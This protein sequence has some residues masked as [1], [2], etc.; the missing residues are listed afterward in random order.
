[1]ATT[2]YY[3]SG[4]R[5]IGPISS[6]AL[7]YHAR[8][9]EI[10]PETEVRSSRS[11]KWIAA[12][13]V[14]GLFAPI[15]ATQVTSRIVQRSTPEQPKPVV[16]PLPVATSDT[17]QTADGPTVPTEIL[18]PPVTNRQPPAI[19]VSHGPSPKEGASASPPIQSLPQSLA[20]GTHSPTDA[21]Q[22]ATAGTSRRLLKYVAGSAV[23]LA[24]V[25]VVGVNVAM[26]L[27]DGQDNTARQ[28][29][30]ALPPADS[31]DAPAS[32]DLV[33][34]Q[35][36]AV[37]EFEEPRTDAPESDLPA[38]APDAAAADSSEDSRKSEPDF[39]DKTTSLAA[40]REHPVPLPEAAVRPNE[41]KPIGEPNPPA[42]PDARIE[43]EGSDRPSV[44]MDTPRSAEERPTVM[45]TD[46][47]AVAPKVAE[48][49]DLRLNRM[50]EIHESILALGDEWEA[51]QREIQA[52][53][54][55]DA[56]LQG[57]QQQIILNI[58]LLKR[59][60][61]EVT[62]SY[63]DELARPGGRP[64]QYELRLQTLQTQL[65]ALQAQGGS[66]QQQSQQIK[67]K[68]AQARRRQ[69]ALNREAEKWYGEWYLLS[70][71]FGRLN[72]ETHRR[73]KELFEQ[74][75]RAHEKLPLPH[76][77]HGFACL[78]LE[79][80]QEALRDFAEVEKL[81]AAAPEPNQQMGALM[82]AVQ[83]YGLRLQMRQREER[84]GEGSDSA[85]ERK[86][87]AQFGKA[88][89]QDSRLGLIN[90]YRAHVHMLDNEHTK[91][92]SE[93]KKGLQLA[94]R[95]DDSAA[96]MVFLYH[97]ECAR[98]LASCPLDGVRNGKQ[99]V[100]HATEACDMTDW[101]EWPYVETLAIAHA[102]RG[103]FAEAAKWAGKALELA[104]PDDRPSL[105]E[106]SALFEKHRPYRLGQE[107]DVGGANSLLQPVR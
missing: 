83:G 24:L 47:K 58:P 101:Q 97:N 98:F 64:R 69:L 103:D 12:V 84:L 49:N 57:Q 44:E 2:W 40:D 19:P 55:A 77:A 54:K 100:E 104:S 63:M 91:A 74:W 106:K 72:A 78:R 89:R 88:S 95:A 61:E 16:P 85:L 6:R 65:Q 50:T 21:K 51:I 76:M 27:L 32:T 29:A 37:D 11:G 102:E 53:L 17:R 107:M 26:L 82:A 70:D 22:Q 41:D 62:R 68:I 33:L 94:E 34:P 60:A 9:H 96:A 59:Q 28:V 67:A 87:A 92:L 18:P 45:P 5:E 35:T 80:Y 15:S 8:R 25:G 1:M 73:G 4:E 20:S 90:L 30:T 42:D 86:I 38:T 79:Q 43:M 81:F 66:L 13:H 71:P 75:R 10:F 23:A 99:A 3:K 39:N 93:L 14:K 36:D 48:G 46:D 52:A 56:G 105:Q 31:S 7:L